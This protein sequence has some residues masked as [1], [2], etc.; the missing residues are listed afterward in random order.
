MPSRSLF[1]VI[2]LGLACASFTPLG[3]QAQT[4]PQQTPPSAANAAATQ[5]LHALFVRYWEETA[6][7]FPEWATWRGDHRYGDRLTDA[8]PAGRVS[9]DMF[10]DRHERG[11]AMFPFDGFRRM[12]LRSV[13]GYQTGFSDLLQAVPVNSPERIEKLFK[14]F[15]AFPLRLDQEVARLRVAVAAGWVPPKSVL[16]RVL[17]Q[18]DGQLNAALDKSPYV[19]PFEKLPRS[20]SE[21]ERAALQ[22]RGR[23]HRPALLSQERRGHVDGLPRHRQAHRWRA[24]QTLCRIATCTVCHLS[25]ART[26]GQRRRVLQRPAARRQPRRAVLCQRHGTGQAPDLG[27]G[28]PGR[29]RGQP[30]AP[31]AKQARHRAAWQA[32]RAARLIV[33]TGLHTMGWARQQAIDFMVERTGVER[34]FVESEVDRYISLPAQ[35]LSYT[36]GKLKIIELRDHAK[37]RL[38]ARFVIRRFHN[39]VLDQGALPLSTLARSIDEWIASEAAAK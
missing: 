34:E 22:A 12:S 38:G 20:M 37:A 17:G 35:V 4:V 27:H 25:H 13:G 15:E 3:T 28:K 10:I 7:L 5:S 19:A 9:L 29:A 2:L 31:P 14:R 21:T 39:A 18:I 24:A 26:P 32:F 6:S 36:I 30:R 33:D 23:D 11:I 1:R 16:E 8:S